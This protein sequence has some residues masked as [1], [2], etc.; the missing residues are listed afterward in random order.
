MSRAGRALSV[1]GLLIA[2]LGVPIALVLRDRYLGLAFLVVGAFLLVLPFSR[3][4]IDED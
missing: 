4:S 2:L 3:P 1:V